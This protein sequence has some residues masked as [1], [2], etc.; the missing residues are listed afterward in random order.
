MRAPT[1]DLLSELHAVEQGRRGRVISGL[2]STVAVGQLFFAAFAFGHARGPMPL[3]ALEVLVGMSFA[4]MI[5]VFLAGLFRRRRLERAADVVLTFQE[6]RRRRRIALFDGYLSVDD[7]VVLVSAVQSAEVDSGHLI[8]RYLD[9]T[10]GP[11]LRD[12]EGT[13]E[14][15]ERVVGATQS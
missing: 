15:L 14:D 6:G 13:A 12:L 3:R 11:V 5:S 2:L 4:L 1:V 7:E 8:L 9:P 10:H